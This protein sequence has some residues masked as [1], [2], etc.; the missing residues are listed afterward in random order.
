MKMI[1][2]ILYRFWGWGGEDD[3]LYNRLLL[4]KH[5]PKRLPGKL[6]RFK[7]SKSIVNLS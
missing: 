3:D 4:R 2:L 1:E 5:K 7:V 6:G